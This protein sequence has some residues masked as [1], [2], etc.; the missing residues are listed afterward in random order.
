MRVSASLLRRLAA[1]GME[2][3]APAMARPG[4]LLYDQA[5]GA[6]AVLVC[7]GRVRLVDSSRMFSSNTLAV[8]V[9]PYLAGLGSSIDGGI[10]ETLLAAEACEFCS[11]R[12]PAVALSFL[13]AQAVAPVEIPALATAAS[14]WLSVNEPGAADLQ[15]SGF[16]TLQETFRPLLARDVQAVDHRPGQLVLYADPVQRA[17]PYGEVIPRTAL[18]Q[19]LRGEVAHRLVLW[20]PAGTVAE[21]EFGDGSA[22]AL[23]PGDAVATA[24]SAR[25]AAA[26]GSD[27][28]VAA[29]AIPERFS[30][31]STVEESHRSILA[32]L[33]SFFAVPSRRDLISR[34]AAYVAQS[35]ASAGINAYIVV[36]E[37]LGLEARVLQFQ[38]TEID[39][40]PLPFIAMNASS[41]PV[42]VARSPAR[43]LCVVNPL[44]QVEA[45]D[46]SGFEGPLLRVVHVYKGPH[47]P[48]RRF[49]LQWL[50]PYINKH[51]LGL[52]EVFVASLFTQLL[53]LASPLL[54]QQIID[55][56]IGQGAKDSLTG[57]AALMVI[58]AILEVIFGSLRTF[59]FADI[60]NRIDIEMG[61]SIIGHMLRLNARY[62]EKRP[63]GELASRLNELDNIRRFLTGT[64]LTVTLD[65]L[66][67]SLYL[68]VMFFYSSVLSLVVLGTLPLLLL[69]TVGLSPLTQRLLRQRAEAYAKTQSLMVE[70][71][72]GIQTL[73]LQS[74]ESITRQKWEDKHLQTINKGFST[75]IANTASSNALQLINKLSSI[76][77]T[78]GG[79]VLVLRN[80]MTLG[81]LIAFRIISSY[82][83]QPVLRL[84]S[85]WQGFQEMTLSFERLADVINQP[86]E[87]P[88]LERSQLTMP[89]LLGAVRFENVS[90]A[91]SNAITAQLSGVSLEIEA[92]AFVGIVGQSGCGKSTLL[93]LL[94]RLYLPTQGK[95]LVDGIDIAKVDLYSFRSQLGYVPQDCLLFE[96]SVLS[97]LTYKDAQAEIDNVVAAAKLASAHEFIMSLPYGY[98]TPIGEKGVGLSGGQR[99]RIA[100][101]RMLL[102]NP[103]MIILDEATSALDFD[104]EQQVVS[105]IRRHA[106]GKTLLM[107]THRLMTLKSADQI[108]V[109]H[110]GNVDSVGDHDSLMARAGRYSVLYQ[111]QSGG[112]A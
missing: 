53:S 6:Q 108:I 102:Q 104:T 31:A 10:V 79:A 51:K 35:F 62:F 63:V 105:N 84:A 27:G 28:S 109:M 20:G 2:T 26:D 69:A 14:N 18:P 15:A 96:G 70:I 67:A 36:L 59:Q 30:R 55:R 22:A 58:F 66:F 56:V 48:E 71:L 40:A 1:L 9:A 25:S 88:P 8:L 112:A 80:E 68:V 21:A 11:V 65:A 49:S 46:L 50:L 99:Q 5:A 78:V 17:Y 77:I 73:K 24:S 32:I 54:F 72:N 111:Q 89:E 38:L 12:L 86:L 64:A 60:S 34:A 93:K 75:I 23:A 82:V 103:R 7:S 100:L 85:A 101:A 83:T 19:L 4:Q 107:I 74:A 3:S 98:S 44:S 37:R 97:N 94:P 61:S 87:S 16:T 81:Q 41:E 47:T 52:L 106:K 39:R 43:G 13:L 91:Y 92:G 90:F 29:L 42:L 45:L 95:V 76:A 110:E 57:L 33:V